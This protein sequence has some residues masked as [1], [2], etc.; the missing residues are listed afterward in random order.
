MANNSIQYKSDGIYYQGSKLEGNQPFDSSAK[1]AD[2][3]LTAA[4]CSGNQFFSNDGAV[5][6][7]IFTLPAP[8]PG[9]ELSIINAEEQSIEIV[10]S[11]SELIYNSNG[12]GGSSKMSVMMKS[13]IVKL[14]CVTSNKWIAE[15]PYI[16]AY[17]DGKNRMVF[18]GGLDTARRGYTDEYLAGLDAW[19]VKTSLS[20]VR[21]HHYGLDINNKGYSVCGYDGSGKENLDEYYLNT[22]TAKTNAPEDKYGHSAQAL[23]GKGYAFSGY[24]SS[25]GMDPTVYEYTPGSNSWV[26]KG[27][28][29]SPNRYLSVATQMDNRAYIFCGYIVGQSTYN[30]DNDE[31]VPDTWASKTDYPGNGIISASAFSI[32]NKCYIYGGW[33]LTNSLVVGY[34]YVLDTWVGK[35]NMPGTGTNNAPGT[36]LSSMGYVTAGRNNDTSTIIKEHREYNL[37]DVWTTKSEFSSPARWAGAAF[38]TH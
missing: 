26:T 28:I 29:I 35:S 34:Q 20:P 14:Y 19:S 24:R 7:I 32:D 6:K 30:K 27:D 3:T 15:Y 33:D 21:S 31:Y 23:N 4:D 16:A 38:S 5:G 22:W 9:Y 36:S 1:T 10:T 18:F 17:N 13:R 25:F 12:T 8:S 11:G 37:C 2:Y